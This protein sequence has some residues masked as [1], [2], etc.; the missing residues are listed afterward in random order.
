MSKR[1]NSKETK[2]SNKLCTVLYAVFYYFF[3]KKYYW[4]QVRY[5]YLVKGVK[6]FDWVKRV[7]FSKNNTVLN[8]RLV[9]KNASNL[10]L[11][12]GSRK[13]LNNGTLEFE[14]ICYLG[15]FPK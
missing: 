4:Y 2:S 7:G 11:L 15:R 5:I 6:I 13:F 8:N 14:F 12:N 10:Y 1:V 9:R 3:P